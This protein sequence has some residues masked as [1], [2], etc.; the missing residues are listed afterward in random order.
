MSIS[1]TWDS[2]PHRKVT[3]LFFVCGFFLGG[4]AQRVPKEDGAVAGTVAKGLS[5]L[6]ARRA[7][8]A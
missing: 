1:L 4:G 8:A 7:G 2:A 6:C 3:G 5:G